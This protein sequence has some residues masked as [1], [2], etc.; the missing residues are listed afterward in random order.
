MAEE[1]GRSA[2]GFG[3]ARGL[4]RPSLGS[5]CALTRGPGD[6]RAPGPESASRPRAESRLPPHRGPGGRRLGWVEG[7]GAG[8]ARP[9]WP[10]GE[11]FHLPFT[12]A[13][14]TP[15][16]GSE[17]PLRFH[18]PENGSR[19]QRSGLTLRP[20]SAQ[21]LVRN[22]RTSPTISLLKYMQRNLR[23]WEE[24][25]VWS[26]GVC[27][28]AA[29]EEGRATPTSPLTSRSLGFFECRREHCEPIPPSTPTPP[30]RSHRLAVCESTLRNVW[31]VG[32]M[33]SGQYRSLKSWGM[34]QSACI[35][36]LDLVVPQ[37]P[38]L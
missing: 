32:Q 16:P 29:P 14:V 34:R 27:V 26:P 33:R 19:C 4:R 37:L 7:R 23:L 38:H 1:G 9:K 22:G 11:Q 35:S 10:L 8:T 36:I 2:L 13:V 24:N 17:R 28:L 12:S 30:I 21:L 3:C 31:S 25:E 15:T 18:R 20:L 6:A 5:P